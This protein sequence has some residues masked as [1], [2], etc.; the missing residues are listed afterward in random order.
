VT[1]RSPPVINCQ[2]TFAFHVWIIC[3]FEICVFCEA[4]KWTMYFQKEASLSVHTH[5]HVPTYLYISVIKTWSILTTYVSLHRGQSV[6]IWTPTQELFISFISLNTYIST[7]PFGFEEGRTR[8]KHPE[9]LRS[10]FIWFSW[11]SKDWENIL[12]KRCYV[13]TFD[14]GHTYIH[15][16]PPGWPDEFV[17]KSHKM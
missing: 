12:I 11:T 7:W 17:K 5:V 2:L 4:Q 3:I 1:K 16:L 6:N 14:F 9:L 10:E 15:T 13:C 8:N